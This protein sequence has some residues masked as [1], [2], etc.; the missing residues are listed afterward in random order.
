MSDKRIMPLW[1]LNNSDGTRLT[2]R[3]MNVCDRVE[4]VRCGAKGR[5]QS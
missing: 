2:I 1:I 4:I 3:M 5:V